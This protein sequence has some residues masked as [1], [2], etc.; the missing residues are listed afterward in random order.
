MATLVD[1]P[2]AFLTPSSAQMMSHSHHPTERPVQGQPLPA[3]IVHHTATPSALGPPLYASISAP[4]IQPSSLLQQPQ[5]PHSL[6]TLS[7]FLSPTHAFEPQRL[8]HPTPSFHTSGLP[9]SS[10]LPQP[11]PHAPHTSHST[12]PIYAAASLPP[13]PPPPSSRSSPRSLKQLARKAELARQ[14]R[15]RKKGVVERME[16]QIRALTEEVARLRERLGEGG[17]GRVRLRVE[18]GERDS[19]GTEDDEVEEEGEEGEEGEGGED[20]A[21]ATST[22]SSV[23]VSPSSSS[24]SLSSSTPPSSANASIPPLQVLCQQ[25]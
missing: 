6:Y 14:S 21:S 17:R 18:E 11:S 24:S 10:S 15:K 7:S 19:E 5:L 4:A 23:D 9:I 16:G 3:A 12:P 20:G 22:G 8:Y 13:P 25:T 1:V 2:R